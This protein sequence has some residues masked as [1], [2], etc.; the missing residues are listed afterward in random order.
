[1]S[2]G[3]DTSTLENNYKDVIKQ[4]IE[5]IYGSLDAA[6]TAIMTA[7]RD[8]EERGYAALGAQISEK[9]DFLNKMEEEYD[10]VEEIVEDIE[11]ER[12]EER[13]EAKSDF[14]GNDAP[15]DLFR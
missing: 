8:R 5:E 6:H 3:E 15:Q 7:E 1:M 9:T 12:E 2:N 13:E 4:F 10:E 14:R 11:D